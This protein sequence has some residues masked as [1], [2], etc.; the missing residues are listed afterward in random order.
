VVVFSDV[1]YTALPPGTPA[2]ELR[3]F[4]RYYL[5][6]EVAHA[7]DGRALPR[8]PWEQWF[9]AGTS[10]SSGL[11][12]AAQELRVSG[13]RRGGVVLLSDLADDPTDLRSLG[14]VL[15]LYEE[16]AIPLRVV[17]LDPKPEDREAW[18]QLLGPGSLANVQ[19]P[20]GDAGRGRLVVESAFPVRL[21]VLGGLVILLLAANVLLTEPIAWR[22]RP[23]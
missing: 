4:A 8:N 11:R 15:S 12:L 10:I 18:A 20:T 19:I 16:R 1:A 17:A 13:A 7:S 6:D 3:S 22:R 5:D 9:S 21:A 23:A 14:L 2:S